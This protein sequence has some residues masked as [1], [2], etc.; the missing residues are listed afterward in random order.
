MV[1]AVLRVLLVA[2]VLATAVHIGLVVAHEPFA[3][4]A[5]NIARDTH[6]EPFSLGNFLEYGT[7]QYLNSNPRIGQWLAYLAYKLEYFAIVSTPLAFLALA[8]AVAILGLGRW[9]SWRRGRDL[10]LCALALGALWYALPRIGML[11]FCRAY[12]T[13]YVYGAAIQ[14]WFLVP[15]RLRVFPLETA[16]PI[17]TVPYFLCGVIAGMC[18]E[19]TGP[20]LAFLM[21]A[22]GVQRQ[23][24]TG[25]R[26]N[27]TWA[28]A[29]GVVVGFAAIF[30]APGQGERYEGLAERTGFVQRLL[31]RGVTGNLDI[32]RDYLGSAAPVIG[33]VLIALVVSR[34]DPEPEPRSR[35]LAL[36][37]GALLAGT[38]ITATVFV[39]PKLGWRFYL[40]SC[41]LL[42]AAFIAVADAALTTHRRL[43]PFVLLSVA[44]SIYAGTRTIPQY[45]RY[46]EAGLAR[47]AALE[48]APRGAVVT[49]DSLGQVADSWWFLGDDFRDIKKRQLVMEYFDLGGVTFRAV[50]IEAPLGITDVRF[51]P[52]YQVTPASCLDEHGGLEIGAFRGIDV[53]AAHEAIG[54][55]IASLRQRIAARGGTLE[56][57]DV[58]VGYV[59][60]PPA[61][62]PPRR[63]IVGRWRP[64]GY[65]GFSARIE[66]GGVGKTRTVRVPKELAAIDAEVFLYQVGGELRRLGTTR[67]RLDYEPWKQPAAYWVLACPA[68]DEVCFVIAATRLQ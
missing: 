62:L 30:F 9:P 65:V 44:A 6:A 53:R 20:T 55:A 7:G 42:L 13:N 18:N 49:A 11:L 38:L 27:L 2:Y 31:Q 45:L 43:V 47:L 1:P 63:L 48:A 61:G 68:Q 26:P 10:A 39:S 66:R 40:H 34:R 36:I 16:R 60:A 25:H 24:A 50:D 19:H 15:V 58:E 57:L 3:F 67:D 28:G 59:G 56:S 64:S 41:A 4:D 51:R 54:T 29:L 5:W 17:V 23:R 46:H 37:G 8:A 35:A 12:S 21:L 14:L 22:Y 52:R 33:L 32:F